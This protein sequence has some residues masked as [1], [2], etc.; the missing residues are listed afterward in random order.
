MENTPSFFNLF[1]AILPLF[2]VVVIGVYFRKHGGMAIHADET[3]LWLLINLFTPCLIIDSFLGN[4][5]LD[6]IGNLLIAPVVGFL[7]VVIGIIFATLAAKCLGFHKK[8]YARTFVACVSLYN[9]GYIPI[10]IIMLFFS[11]DVL[12][13]LF[14]Y[15]VGLEFA[16]WTLGYLTLVGKSSL[17]D[18]LNR[19]ITPP[20]IAVIASLIINAVC[21]ES[22]LPMSLGRVIHMIGQSTIP[23]ALLLVGATVY[24]HLPSFRTIHPVKPVLVGIFLRLF[25]IPLVFVAMAFIL[26]LPGT[27]KTVLCVQ[28]GMPSAVLPIVLVRQHGGDLQLAIRIILA[29]SILCLFT[30]PAWLS[31]AFTR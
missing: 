7:T 13:M 30:L 8:E 14:V 16:M 3:I 31:L 26:P 15:N 2:M 17:K 27:L 4:R 21:V 25:L 6:D 19:A 29:T 9:Y 23:M 12:G 5:A 24:D 18:S 20:L 11:K 28:A 1:F 10:P 22:P